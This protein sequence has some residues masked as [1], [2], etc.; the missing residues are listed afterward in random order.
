MTNPTWPHVHARLNC[1]HEEFISVFPSNHVLAV[2]GDRIRALTW[3]CEMTGIT[4]ILLGS[5]AADRTPPL[6]E[7]LN[8]G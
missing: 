4:P 1:S 2:E 7:R 5:A 8:H 3:A 6:W